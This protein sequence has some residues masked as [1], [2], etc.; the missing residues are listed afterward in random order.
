MT[1]SEAVH[2]ISALPVLTESKEDVNSIS[3]DGAYFF[4]KDDE[5]QI[6]VIGPMHFSPVS[7]VEALNELRSDCFVLYRNSFLL[8]DLIKDEAVKQIVLNRGFVNLKA[9]RAS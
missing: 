4:V 2:D 8:C 1:L 5:A 7:Y 6:I 3:P 9:R